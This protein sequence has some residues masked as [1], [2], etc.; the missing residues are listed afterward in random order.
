MELRVDG[1][2]SD[3]LVVSSP[4]HL[5]KADVVL[6]TAQRARPVTGGERRR[7]IQEEEL[8]EPAGLH[9]RGS[10]PATKFEPTRDPAPAG[11]SAPDPPRCVVQASTI[12]V[13]E[14]SC[15]MRDQLA[16]G[17]D[18][19]LERHAQVSGGRPTRA[20]A[21]ARRPGRRSPPRGRVR[22]RLPSLRQTLLRPASCTGWPRSCAYAVRVRK[23][24]KT[25]RRA[26]FSKTSL[27]SE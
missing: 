5:G 22:C 2:S 4:P 21:I 3:R 27:A 18:S 15:R 16:G 7:L 14:P 6:A 23:S 20:P 24:T 9:E 1:I 8:R 25:S 10:V 17:R 13:H 19:V 11:V 12:A 26:T